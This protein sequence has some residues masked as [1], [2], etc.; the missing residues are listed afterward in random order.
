MM[1]Q[2]SVDAF[3]FW[4]VAGIFVVLAGNLIYESVIVHWLI[5]R[6]RKR[7]EAVCCIEGD[8]DE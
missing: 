3:A 1:P 5:E 7:C 6:E 4:I 8:D 2:N